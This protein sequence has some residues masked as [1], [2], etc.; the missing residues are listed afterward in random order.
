M[1]HSQYLGGLDLSA[2]LLGGRKIDVAQST[3]MVLNSWKG[4]PPVDA[5][6]PDSGIG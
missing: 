5:G 6:F 2:W 4:G 1:I 3:D